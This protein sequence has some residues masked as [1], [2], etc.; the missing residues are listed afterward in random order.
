MLKRFKL[1]TDDWKIVRRALFGAA[2]FAALE[3]FDDPRDLADAA[4]VGAIVFPL[5]GI[6][7]NR[8][9]IFLMLPQSLAVEHTTSGANVTVN[10]PKKY[11]LSEPA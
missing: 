11:D 10:A 1:D 6:M 2:L 5:V 8:Q 3:V 7:M 4:M 9:P